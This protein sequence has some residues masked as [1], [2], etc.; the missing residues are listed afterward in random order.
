MIQ[1]SPLSIQQD[2]GGVQSASIT[3]CAQ[4]EYQM[5]ADLRT[6][7]EYI[8]VFGAMETA[9]QSYGCAETL[10]L[11]EISVGFDLGVMRLVADS[12]QEQIGRSAGTQDAEVVRPDRSVGIY[13][14]LEAELSVAPIEDSA[15]DSGFEK[16][17]PRGAV[18][19]LA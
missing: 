18:E 8:D 16:F 15:M 11:I 1:L 3:G 2:H 14:Q 6:E 5:L 4:V 13:L 9:V 10:G 19:M 7:S 12:K 17:D